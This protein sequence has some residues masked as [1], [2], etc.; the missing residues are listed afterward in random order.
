MH[1]GALGIHQIKL[2]VDAR[3]D[4]RDGSGVADHAASTH[5][6]GQVTAWDHGWWLIIDSAFKARRTPINK[7][8]GALGLDG[9]DR[10]VHILW[11]HIAAVHHAACHV[12]AMARVALH[13]HRG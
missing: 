3:E 10:R 9:G 7:L 12:F 11:Y 6:L 8:D 5:Y 4:F 2:V 1:K 13:K